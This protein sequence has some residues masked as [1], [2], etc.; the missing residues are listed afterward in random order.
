LAGAK[1]SNLII[2]PPD[3]PTITVDEL[4]IAQFV[5]LLLSN[6]KFRQVID[7]ITAKVVLIL[8]RFSPQRQAIL[9]AILRELRHR[10]YLPISLDVEKSSRREFAETVS[11]LAH[12]ARFIIVDI[13]GAKSMPQELQ[14]ILPHLPS[15]AVQP[16]MASSDDED[17]AL[18]YFG[19][20][21]RVLDIHR[22]ETLEVLQASLGE[23]VIAPAEK[24]AKELTY[25]TQRSISSM[26]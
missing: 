4:E 19:G 11:T 6:D 18:R 17:A 9:E 26:A 13:S 23:K 2:T 21:S 7:A 25:V 20:Y 14:R 1:Q 5:S 16:L 12:M 24:K 8:V 22:Y 10:D 3:E 15:V